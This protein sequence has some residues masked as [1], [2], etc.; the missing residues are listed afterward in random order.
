[1]CARVPT[2]NVSDCLNCV[3]GALKWLFLTYPIFPFILIFWDRWSNI[4]TYESFKATLYLE[5]NVS[6]QYK[7][8]SNTLR[9]NKFDVRDSN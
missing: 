9:F 6:Y 2:K 8:K 5:S 7:A 3:L 4:Q 1:M